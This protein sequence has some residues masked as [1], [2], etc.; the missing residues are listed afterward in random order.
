MNKLWQKPVVR[1]FSRLLVLLILCLVIIKL[2]NQ[3]PAI[4]A[5]NEKWID[6]HTRNNGL[7][8]VIQ[9]FAVATILLSIG[10][11]RQFVAFLAGYA[12]G[13][14]EGL[15]YST[16]AATASCALTFLLSRF[17]ARPIVS[18]LFPRQINRV[19]HFL[20]V[21]PFAMTIMIRLM[22]FGN[23]LI[24]NLISGVTSVNFIAFLAGSFIGYLPQ[25]AI[26]ALM[27]KG[28]VVQSMWKIILSTVLL[29]ISSFI[30]IYLYKKL[31][32]QHVAEH[33]SAIE[34]TR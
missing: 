23:N 10:V 13:F 30:G 15:I 20:S 18:R 33:P 17:Y 6:G 28:V 24:T 8:G 4:D 19:N 7:Q 3:I 2:T 32:V 5:F 34:P 29:A 14:T 21:Q 25:M 12:F 9:F 31:K 16:L 27:G 26:F 11:P 1:V 22:P